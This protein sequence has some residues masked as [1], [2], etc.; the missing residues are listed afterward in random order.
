MLKTGPD[1]KSSKPAKRSTVIPTPQG[2]ASFLTKEVKEFFQRL[3]KAFCEE[4]VLQHF[5]VSKPIRLETDASG[6]AIGGV[7]CQQDAYINWHLVAY[8]SSKMLPAELSYETHNNELLAI[9]EAFKTWRYYLEGAAHTILIFT[10]HNNLKKFR[11]TTRLS[12]RQIR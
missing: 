8:Y 2:L 3:K 1:S 10:D 4:P 7:L 9:V 5:D 11:E 12:D 6:K